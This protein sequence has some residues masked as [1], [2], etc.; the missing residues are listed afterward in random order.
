[1][2]RRDR[3]R[4]RSQQA[5]QRRQFLPSQRRRS[6]DPDRPSGRSGGGEGISRRDLR[7][8]RQGA[9]QDG[10]AGHG[11]HLRGV[12]ADGERRR[13]RETRPEIPQ[14]QGEPRLSRRERVACPAVYC[15]DRRPAQFRRFHQHRG[16]RQRPGQRRQ[17]RSRAAARVGDIGDPRAADPR[18]RNGQ[19]PGRLRPD[20]AGPGPDPH[21]GG[22]RRPG[23]SRQRSV[24]DPQEHDRRSAHPPRD[25]GRAADREQLAHRYVGAGSLY[26]A[27]TP[28]LG[29]PPLFGR[30]ELPA[31]PRQMGLW[32]DLL[33]QRSDHLLPPG[34]DRQA[35]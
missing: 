30:C 29:L 26:L 17:C 4:R 19:G 15:P 32:S 12:A 27:E 1:M 2:E 3:S 24:A 35:V 13:G 20:L 16:A 21:S 31:G 8:R 28:F 10:E 33:R 11:P 18:R 23:Q 5:R 34:R 14:A 25:Q 6:A 9:V 22:L 7:Q